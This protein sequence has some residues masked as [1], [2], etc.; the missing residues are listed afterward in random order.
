MTPVGAAV[1]TGTGQRLL[2]GVLPQRNQVSL[3][4]FL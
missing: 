4:A 3:I 1:G 2:S